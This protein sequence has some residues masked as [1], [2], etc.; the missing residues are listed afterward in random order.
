LF[1]E[2]LDIAVVDVA[3]ISLKHVLPVL[4]KLGVKKVLALVKPQFEAGR[5]EVGKGGVVRDPKVQERTVKEIARFAQELG[6]E[7]K[8]SCESPLKGPKGNREFFLL[9]FSGK[10]K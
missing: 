1:D 3:F 9:F 6:F 4:K 7:V 5:A 8:G 2:P 10:E